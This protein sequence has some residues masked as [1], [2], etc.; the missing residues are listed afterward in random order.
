MSRA[1]YP[2]AA[3]WLRRVVVAVLM[4]F[5]AWISTPPALIWSSGMMPTSQSSVPRGWTTR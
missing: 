4:P 2:I 1:E 3:S 5:A